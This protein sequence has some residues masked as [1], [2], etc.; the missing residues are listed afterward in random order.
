MSLFRRF[1]NPVRYYSPLAIGIVRPAGT[2]QVIAKS[3]ST[4]TVITPIQTLSSTSKFELP[5]ARSIP[6]VCEV[7]GMKPFTTVHAFNDN[8]LIDANMVPCVQLTLTTVAG[9]FLGYSDVSPSNTWTLLR[10]LDLAD[11]QGALQSLYPNGYWAHC[12]MLTKGETI[13]YYTSS[14]TFYSGI[15]VAQQ[16]QLNPVTRVVQTVLHVALSRYNTT[17]SSYT[18]NFTSSTFTNFPVA[19]VVKGDISGATGTITAVTVPT[20]LQTNSLGNFYGLYVIPP[21][22]V[23]A[24]KHT[25]S[26]SDSTSN[27]PSN[28]VTNASGSFTSMGE[29]DVK[30]N[31]F[32][33]RKDTY[34]TTVVTQVS[35]IDPLAQSFVLPKEKINGC[36]V[37]SVDIFFTQKGASET[38]PVIC[39]IVDMENGYP[40]KNVLF[41]AVAQLSPDL[42][43]ADTTGQTAT[44]FRFNGPVFLQPGVEYAIKILSNSI[45]YKVAIAQMGEAYLT[46][47]TKIV[48][49]HPYLGVLFKSQNNSTW[50]ADQMQVMKFNINQAVFNTAAS[51]LLTVQNQDNTSALAKL[52]PNPFL[53]ANGQTTVKV[54]FPDHGLFAGGQVTF[55]GS[56]TTAF[57]ATFQVAAVINSNYFTI[58]T[59]AQATSGLLGGSNVTATKSTKYDTIYVDLG[60]EYLVKQGTSITTTVLPATSNAKDTVT[61]TVNPNH[62]VD[63]VGGSRYVHST[64]NE[65]LFLSGRKSLDVNIN[66]V[67]TSSDLSPMLNRNSLQAFLVTNK[68]NT[69]VAANSTVVDTHTIVSALAG[70][71]FTAATGIIGVPVTQDINQFKIGANITISGTTSNNITTEIINIDTSTTPYSVY[72]SGTLVNESPATTTIVQAEGYIDEIAPTGGTAEA[73]YQTQRI[74]LDQP[75][76]GMQIML[77]ASIPPAADIQVYYRTAMT[78]ATTQL[79]STRWYPVTMSYRK[80]QGGEFIDQQYTINALNNYNNAQFKIVFKTTDTTQVPQIKDF[81]VICLS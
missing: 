73:K 2:T 22:I 69:D 48:T 46:D 12:N 81:R 18:D 64:L 80:S 36:F 17:G 70:V 33:Q 42:I 79:P 21:G 23:R 47:P 1:F 65:N 39:Q 14:T 78:T 60:P 31:T 26:F 15:V 24:G 6:V 7:T 37:T 35:Y 63:M 40:T 32:V 71:T 50:T 19:G 59:A 10:D 55:S 72:V 34:T 38:Q 13:R 68:I 49:Q 57:N 16:Q 44:R 45:S 5:F 25:I 54:F 41:N 62:E 43:T 3:S 67:S 61:V 74:V 28:S 8:Q 58:T 76:T 52:P 75:A 53:V 51:G 20:S 66:L 11:Y 9:N 27:D 4:S 56:T 77:S 30:T 29:L